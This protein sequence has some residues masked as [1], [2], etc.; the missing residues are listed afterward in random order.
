[1][2]AAPWLKLLSGAIQQAS[3]TRINLAESR[4]SRKFAPSNS[5]L[6]LLTSPPIASFIRQNDHGHDQNP[7]LPAILFPQ[8]KMITPL[9]AIERQTLTWS[10][11]KI[12]DGD[13]DGDGS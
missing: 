1:V 12:V 3:T 7:S 5:R 4:L 9:E 11:T 2:F 10:L 13:G 6:T 8:Q